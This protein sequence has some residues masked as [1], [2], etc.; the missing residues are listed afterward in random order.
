MKLSTKGKYGLR[1]F[2][3]M[4]IYCEDGPVT[5]SSIA[6]RQD[7]PL[8]YLEKLI[9]KLKQAGLVQSVRGASGGYSLA[10]PADTYTVGEVL[11][12]LEGELLTV[13]CAGLG[14]GK[15]EHCAGSKN[16]LTK[17]VWE[18]ISDSI[19]QTVDQI[20]IGDLIR[21]NKNENNDRKEEG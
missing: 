20:N 21:E 15:V 5:L 2:I 19:N 7:I 4:A 14:S 16:C 17:Q 11:R 6:K 13:E 3:D 1:A 8:S 12:T 18:K 10:R 9:G